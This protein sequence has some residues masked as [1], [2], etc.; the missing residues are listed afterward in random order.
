M[1]ETTPENL[2]RTMLLSY[3]NGQRGH[4]LG[5]LED[6]DDEALR[7]QVLPSGWSCLG[8]IQHLTL[9]VERFWFSGIVAGEQAVLDDLNNIPNAWIVDPDVSAER[10]LNAYRQEISRADAIVANVPLDSAPALWPPDLF[11]DWRLHSLRQVILHVLTE[12]ACHTGH[13]DVVRELIDDR[14]WLVLTE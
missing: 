8:L 7:R 5:I 11:G 13:L 9:D 6:L 4:V 1:V 10:I 2:E 12:T 14:Q 3:L